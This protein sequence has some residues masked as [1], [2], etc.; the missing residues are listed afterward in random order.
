MM[1]S[2]INRRHSLAVRPPRRKPAGSNVF[3]F[4]HLKHSLPFAT[5]IPQNSKTDPQLQFQKNLKSGP[6][7]VVPKKRTPRDL[8]EYDT[9]GLLGFCLVYGGSDLD[10]VPIPL[11]YSCV[12]HPVFYPN[13]VFGGVSTDRLAHY[14]ARALL[15]S[16]H[17]WGN[18]MI[19]RAQLVVRPCGMW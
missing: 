17:H 18:G 4:A 7:P 15:C 2:I 9:L 11:A 13:V 6:K 1:R 3:L 16:W 8:W 14:L 10:S 19:S 5:L 12:A